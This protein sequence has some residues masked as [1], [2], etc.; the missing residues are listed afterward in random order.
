MRLRI[1]LTVAA[2]IC[3]TS[4]V[5]IAAPGCGDDDDDD[6]DDNDDTSNPLDNLDDDTAGD[7]PYDDGYAGADEGPACGGCEGCGSCGGEMDFDQTLALVEDFEALFTDYGADE[8]GYEFDANDVREG[9]A[10]CFGAMQRE[11]VDCADSAVNC[12]FDC[13]GD[14]C[15]AACADAAAGCFKLADGRFQGCLDSTGGECAGLLD[16]GRDCRDE[17]CYAS[18]MNEFVACEPLVAVAARIECIRDLGAD[19]AFVGAAADVMALAAD[20]TACAFN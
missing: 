9:D 17:A 5:L 8:L 14:G 3:I 6:N 18:C 7:N 4:I 13:D 12:A 15:F 2:L 10:A 19:F 16:C 1:F 20:Y 11:V